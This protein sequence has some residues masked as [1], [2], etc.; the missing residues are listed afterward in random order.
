MTPSDSALQFVWVCPQ[1]GRRVPKQIEHCRC[2][3]GQPTST[4]APVSSGKTFVGELIV[5]DSLEQSWRDEAMR[6][7]PGHAWEG[8]EFEW[9]ASYVDY[10][11]K[12]EKDRQE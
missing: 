3:F 12:L 2:G 6:Q 5:S 8:R 10:K 4:P 11:R 1:C 9:V 7:F